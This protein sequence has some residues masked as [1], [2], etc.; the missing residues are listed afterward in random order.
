M[1]TQPQSSTRLAFGPFQV[2]VANGELFKHGVRVR[3]PGQPFQILLLLLDRPGTVVTREELR[4]QIWGG[5]TFVDFE[6]SLNVAM[7]KLRRALGDSAENPRYIETVPGRGYRFIGSMQTLSDAGAVPEVTP[8]PTL[9][10]VPAASKR[11]RWRTAAV[12]LGLV[13]IVAGVRGLLRPWNTTPEMR[14][15]QLTT[16]AAENPV[17]H[18]VIS[19]DGKYLAYGDLAG[20][21]VR[22]MAT[23]ETHLLPRPRILRAGD[24]WFPAA[25]F[26]DGTRIL[27]TSITSTAVNAWKVS[28]IGGTAIAVRDNAVVQSVSPD[29]SLVAF[30]TSAHMGSGENEINRRLIWNSEIW[31]M[32]PDGE[33]AR[34]VMSG[35]NLTYFG[36]VRWS[37][38]GRR[39]AYQKYRFANGEAVKYTIETCDRTG[40][41]PTTVL[42]TQHY[43]GPSLDHIFPEDFC[44]LADGR[45]VYAV[46]EEPPNSR[47]SNL[48]EV[49]VDTQSGTPRT[50]PRR[51]TRLAG[52][53]MEGLSVAAD[54]KRLLFESS[55]DQSHIYVGEL[56]ADGTLGVP[57]RLTPD[58]RYNTPYGWTADSKAVIFRSDRTGTFLLYKQGLDQYVPEMIPT[59][60]GSPS[61]VRV[62][63]D[64]A[65]VIYP[66]L[67]NVPG[68]S[69]L[70]R[71]PLAGGAPQVIFERTRVLN[72]SCSHRSDS[73]CVL[74]ESTPDGNEYV[75]SGF[76]PASAARHELFRLARNPLNWNVSPDGSRIAVIGDD[77]QGRIEIRSLT[78]QVEFTVEPRGW[79]HPFTVDWS[80]D[81]KTLFVSHPGLTDDPS[82][83][84]GA[85]VLHVNLDGH[86]QPLWETRGGRYAWAIPSP[87]GKYLA[88]R[89]ATTGRNAWLIDNF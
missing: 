71:V 25:W 41:A 46:R 49:A 72:F 30:V 86:V 22:L 69:R 17:W 76:N 89:G 5:E 27:A 8:I 38:D 57:R 37:P 35:D 65:G 78:G 84:I 68:E 88:I 73:L 67:S 26:P 79:P 45:I 1:A 23:G 15:Q 51:I 55:T 80:A 3:L 14:V 70:M 58:E 33:N 50:R 82:G 6:H 12:G 21:Q 43:S 53:H 66:V 40:G 87:D 61:F 4:D 56:A 63:P 11:S 47:D 34:K 44:W 48:W 32:G 64:G 54:T 20:I 18:A 39:I 9:V 10:A 2:N 29:G 28:V 42:S 83:P 60:A 31:T 59:G 77:A 75:F 7:N 81:G 62:S 13:A 24:A 36:S 52:F 85:T 74:A 19:P 16:N